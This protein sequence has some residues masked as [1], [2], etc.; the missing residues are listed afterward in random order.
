[1]ANQDYDVEVETKFNREKLSTAIPIRLR[2][3]H[4]A[5]RVRS[6]GIDQ[7][8][9]DLLSKILLSVDRVCQD[10]LETTNRAALSAAA[11]NARN[12]LELWVWIR[13]CSTS[14][15]NARRFHEDALRDT[16][17]LTE[18][19]SKMHATAGIKNEFEVSANQKAAKLAAEIG[20]GSLDSKYLRV[21]EAAKSIGLD[22][23]YPP[24]NAHLSKL[25]H[26]TAVLVVGLMHQEEATLRAWQ[27]SCTTQGLYFAGQCVI[28]LSEAASAI[29][30]KESS[31]KA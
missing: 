20:I 10:L 22:N 27:C 15:A 18:S 16:Q 31:A 7:W 6:S 4:E 19:L 29:S 30:A 13:F 25:A 23:W 21:A 24:C 14:P 2:G 3:L 1:M 28:A 26:P 12:L 5:L 8:Y 11:W 17:G 9:V